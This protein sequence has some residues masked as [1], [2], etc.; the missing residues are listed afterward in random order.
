MPISW[1]GSR[2]Q[3]NV[4]PSVTIGIEARRMAD[5]MPIWDGLPLK[6]EHMAKEA[7]SKLGY[8]RS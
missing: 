3:R 2:P 8:V 6:A 5:I 1:I 4:S 7:L